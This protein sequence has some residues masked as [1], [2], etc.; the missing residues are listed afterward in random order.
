MTRRTPQRGAKVPETQDPAYYE[1]LGRAIKVARTELGLSRKEL[2]ARAKISYPYI[3]D[4]ESGRGRPSSSALL[5]VAGALGL[6]P[7]T[8]M[9]MG[10]SF[11]QRMQEPSTA[12]EAPMVAPAGSSSS[13]FRGDV[14]RMARMSSPASDR[15]EPLQRGAS[16]PLQRG[17]GEREELHRL[18][19]EL[20]D[21][22]LQLALE[23][24]RR[25]LGELPPRSP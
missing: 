4:I 20:P 10:E 18:I 22:D 19:D 12:A 21:E 2:A 25:L 13:W 15:E 6:S 7:S 16:E 8:L 11:V 5:A 9:A 14:P 3:A 23:L 17:A 1:A 24:A